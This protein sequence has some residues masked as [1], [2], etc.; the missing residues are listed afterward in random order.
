[1][2]DQGP[3]P[4]QPDP[5]RPDPLISRKVTGSVGPT[6]PVGRAQVRAENLNSNMN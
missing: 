2:L 6:Q 3:G 4:T 5:A 1:M